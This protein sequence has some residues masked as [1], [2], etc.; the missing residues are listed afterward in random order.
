MDA[1]QYLDCGEERKQGEIDADL[2]KKR[3]GRD[4]IIIFMRSQRHIED[5]ASLRFPFD[6]SEVL[7]EAGP[8]FGRI[9]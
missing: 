3:P 9:S 8:C 6:Q 7:S 5:W 2:T 4:A 1:H